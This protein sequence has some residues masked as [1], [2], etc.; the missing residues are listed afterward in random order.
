MKKRYNKYAMSIAQ[1]FLAVLFK[2]RGQI[3]L[4][5]VL[6]IGSFIMIMVLTLAF[7][8]VSIVSSGRLI[9]S[10]N[11]ALAISSA[12]VQDAMLRLIR[13]N[14]FDED[15]QVSAGGDTASVDITNTA[16]SDGRVIVV[17]SSTVNSSHRRVR[18][19]ISIVSSTGQVNLIS[20]EQL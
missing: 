1:S 4:T 3:A 7:L 6:L 20:M 8:S 5:T 12:G 19:I 14:N 11:R 9:Q 10:S 2:E 17:S 18:A 16:S 15:F 13:D